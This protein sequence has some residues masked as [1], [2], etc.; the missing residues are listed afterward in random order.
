MK[1]FDCF[2]YFEEIELLELR[3]H[4]VYPVV[5]Y[6][7]LVEANQTFMGKAKEFIFEKN[8]HKFAPFLDKIIYVKVE[9]MPASSNPWELETHQRNCIRRGLDKVEDQDLVLISDLDEIPNPSAIQSLAEPRVKLQLEKSPLAFTQ[10]LFYYYLNCVD[11]S[12]WHGT[13]AAKGSYIKKSKSIELD[14]RKNRN[15]FPRLRNGGW[16]FTYM[17][18]VEKIIRKIHSVSEQEKNTPQNNDPAFIRQQIDNGLMDIHRS[19][20]APGR[21][22]KLDDTFPAYAAT[23]IQQYP[24]FYRVQSVYASN[25]EAYPSENQKLIH[26]QWS[27][28]KRK[29]KMALKKLLTK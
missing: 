23:L 20:S 11:K 29:V 1:I 15:Y 19:A 8:K 13:V 26:N 4:T 2:T 27:W 12:F 9:D 7:V 21:F 28:Q 24:F 17:G 5:D 14:I 3:L 25:I 18:G 6:I 16:H 22:V 10:K